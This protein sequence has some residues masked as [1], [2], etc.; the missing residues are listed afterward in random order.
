[1]ATRVRE[2][3]ATF[4]DGP[5]HLLLSLQQGQI[6]GVHISQY[7]NLISYHHSNR[8]IQMWRNNDIS[9]EWTGSLLWGQLSDWSDSKV[10]LFR[11]AFA[12]WIIQMVMLCLVPHYFAKLAVIVGV[13]V[14]AADFIYFTY[15]PK[16]FQIRFPSPDGSMSVLDF[17]FS[18]CFFMTI[19]AG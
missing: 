8:L 12:F 17:H 3:F 16:N 1:M 11:T 2:L 5:V 7:T 18:T 10:D 15:L 4:M 13:L 19:A 14:L 9:F 6:A